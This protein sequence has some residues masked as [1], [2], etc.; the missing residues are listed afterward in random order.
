MNPSCLGIKPV[1]FTLHKRQPHKSAIMLT[2]GW[3][4]EK[5]Y[6]I[7]NDLIPFLAEK[8]NGAYH[9]PIHP[10]A[11]EM[12]VIV[13]TGI[14]RPAGYRGGAPPRSGE[15]LEPCVPPFYPHLHHQLAGK[16]TGYAVGVGEGGFPTGAE[17]FGVCG[18]LLWDCRRVPGVEDALP[19]A[20]RC[21]NRIRTC[22]APCGC[23]GWQVFSRHALLSGAGKIWNRS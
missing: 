16:L 5:S 11:E 4:T 19:A 7:Q 9:A 12:E 6:Y 21:N 1:Y 14:R 20:Q 10:A 3:G 22:S 18:V 13:S 2:A 17:D 8:E 15:G 23:P